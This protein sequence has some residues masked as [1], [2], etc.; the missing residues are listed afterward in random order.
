M[1]RKTS[2][3]SYFIIG[4]IFLVVGIYLSYNFLLQFIK[5]I[6]GLFLIFTGLGLMAGRTV[7][8]FRLFR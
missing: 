1:K 5:I 4:I 8:H 7:T 3:I 2:D 6:A